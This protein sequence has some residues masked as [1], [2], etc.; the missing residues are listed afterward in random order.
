[1][2]IVGSGP[3]SHGVRVQCEGEFFVTVSQAQW[4]QIRNSEHLH[5]ILPL[6]AVHFIG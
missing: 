2:A 1:L 4:E 3:S 6:A 5:V